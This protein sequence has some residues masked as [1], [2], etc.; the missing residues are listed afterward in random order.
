[1]TLII[2]FIFNDDNCELKF[3]LP[4]L[5]NFKKKKKTNIKWNENLI[6][7][8]DYYDNKIERIKMPNIGTGYEHWT[9]FISDEEISKFTKENTYDN[10]LKER[11][12]QKIKTENLSKHSYKDKNDIVHEIPAIMLLNQ[13]EEERKKG[14]FKYNNPI[15][16]LTTQ[17]LKTK[18]DFREYC[19]YEKNVIEQCVSELD[20]KIE[21]LKTN[22][23]VMLCWVTGL[24]AQ[25][26][27]I[28]LLTKC[29][30]HMNNYLKNC[31][32]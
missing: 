22:E 13:I 19:K 11:D 10:I 4:L 9:H 24:S 25:Q 30:N 27:N 1:M 16:F 17:F 29:R 6:T 32:K 26:K 5:N 8:V 14:W 28:P 2:Q 18:E 15:S 3:I 12:T 21:C 31:N 7:K 23:V 20:L